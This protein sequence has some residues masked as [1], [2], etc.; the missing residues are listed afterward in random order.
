MQQRQNKS[1]KIYRSK[2]VTEGQQVLSFRYRRNIFSNKGCTGRIRLFTSP[3]RINVP[4]RIINGRSTGTIFSYQS[5]R[6]KAAYARLK[7]ECVR[8]QQVITTKKQIPDIFFIADCLAEF[9]YYMP[10]KEF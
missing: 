4:D 1:K 7:E 6:P 2:I 5:S 10:E 9:V 8:M 3:M